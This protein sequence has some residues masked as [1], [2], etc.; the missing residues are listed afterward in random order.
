[1]RKRA[2]WLVLVVLFL[3]VLALLAACQLLP[4]RAAPV[5]APT[6]T[7]LRII[8]TATFTP[9]VTQTPPPPTQTPTIAPTD[10]P[11]V[12]PTAS[13]MP[14]QIQAGTQRYIPAF[15]RPEQGCAWSGIAGQVFDS[16]GSGAA[17][18]MVMITGSVD[19]KTVDQ[20]EVTAMQS[21]YGPGGY[22][23]TLADHLPLRDEGLL[24]Q[25]FDSQG[26]VLSDAVP[27][28]MSESCDRNLVLM[29]FQAR[30]AGADA[31]SY[32]E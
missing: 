12:T 9:T 25:L 6:I 11:T 3:S 17:G 27:F 7:P 1:M 15:T 26:H 23:V 13:P 32:G 19:G 2:F 4:G 30:D 20:V 31:R 14:Y 28:Q 24:I 8:L 21:A 5:P 22:E 29:N 18:V 16:T 10:I